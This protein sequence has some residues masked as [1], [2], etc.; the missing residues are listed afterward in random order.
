MSTCSFQY[1]AVYKIKYKDNLSGLARK[2]EYLPNLLE[3]TLLR[4]IFVYRIRDFKFWQLTY[5]IF[6]V[7]RAKFEPEKTNF[8]EGPP[9][10]YFCYFSPTKVQR[11]YKIVKLQ[12]LLKSA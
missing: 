3:S 6:L 1:K 5:F 9:F 10:Q 2:N 7:N 4:Q 12:V 8:F 11:A